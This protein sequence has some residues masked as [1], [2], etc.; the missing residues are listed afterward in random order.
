MG[1][2]SA[3][4][5]D[6]EKDTRTQMP[7]VGTL[8]GQRET[9]GPTGLAEHGLTDRA[10]DAVNVLAPPTATCSTVDL[11][12]N[13]TSPASHAHGS[14]LADPKPRTS[15]RLLVHHLG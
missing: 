14:L 13:S 7:T 2:G 11:E 3:L 6:F 5:A 9:D 10:R 4:S 12:I 1:Q 15:E 8:F